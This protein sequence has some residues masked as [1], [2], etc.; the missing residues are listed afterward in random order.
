[1][2]TWGDNDVKVLAIGNYWPAAFFDVEHD[3]NYDQKVIPD[4]LSKHILKKKHDYVKY[5][6][7]RN[8][9]LSPDFQSYYL[10]TLADSSAEIWHQIPKTQD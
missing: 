10:I 4:S 8:L 1:M 2:D 7:M 3:H 5:G 6:K 9:Q